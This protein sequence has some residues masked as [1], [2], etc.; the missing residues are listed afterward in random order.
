MCDFPSWL[1]TSEGEVK[2]LKDKDVEALIEAGTI[3]T[4]EDG[5]GHSAAEKVFGEGH[6]HREKINVPREIQNAIF[7]GEMNRMANA[8]GYDVAKI[9]GKIEI[10]NKKGF[11]IDVAL[12]IKFG[13]SFALSCKVDAR[14]GSMVVACAGS[15][16]VACAGSK[17][18]A[19]DGSTVDAMD[20]SK[21]DA[22]DGSTV[23][24]M[25]GSMVDACA[26]SKVVASAGSK[27]DARDGSTVDAM[28]GSTVF[29]MDGS[30]VDARAGSK[31][32]A[33]NGSKVIRK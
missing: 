23:F 14:D 20:G 9:G 25:A 19:R 5:V 15:K 30:M 31:V 4:W 17:V 27:V 7:N 32:V 28:D 2:F 13:F 33:R 10:E 3:K 8:A 6:E 11:F 12:S 29:A 16:V 18:D 1:F 22:M 26:G 21:V 24:A